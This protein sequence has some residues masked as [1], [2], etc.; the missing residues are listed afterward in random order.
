M[1]NS[2][3]IENDQGK[4]TEEL[5]I[6]PAY[7]EIL[8]S[9]PES[10]HSQVI[11]T[12]KKW[13]EGVQKKITDLHSTYDPY[14]NFIENK[15]DPE[16]LEQAAVL[17]D[18][19][20]E[21]PEEVVAKAVEHYNLDWAQKAELEAELEKMKKVNDNSNPDPD[22]DD[23]VD[24]EEDERFVEVQKTTRE[25]AEWRKAQEEEKKAAQEQEQYEEEMK[26][27]HTKFGEFDDT[28]VT[29]FMLS[30]MD[31]EKAVTRWNEIVNQ[32]AAATNKENEPPAPPVVLGGNGSGGSGLPNGEISFGK[33]KNT[34]LNS[35]VA[36]IIAKSQQS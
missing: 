23:L 34:D 20:N 36:E 2:T 3:P 9:L 5:K 12:L 21:N 27:L 13:D 33:M 25:L 10:L 29:A 18:S 31:G 6:H 32:A 17:L 11:P 7:Q 1:T 35:A 8:D 28:G 24:L 22:D 26:N 16:F 14:K 4:E 30:G 15:V 19:F